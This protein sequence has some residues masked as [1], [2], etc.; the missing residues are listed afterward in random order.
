MG[1]DGWGVAGLLLVD[2]AAIA[3]D[4]NRMIALHCV[5]LCLVLTH[6]GALPYRLTGL[7]EAAGIGSACFVS[8]ATGHGFSLRVG[9]GC[10]AFFL[11]RVDSRQGVVEV[12][13]DGG[14]TLLKL[15]GPPEDP[16]R[17]PR[18]VPDSRLSAAAVWDGLTV[19]ETRLLQRVLSAPIPRPSSAVGAGRD[20]ELVTLRAIM[21]RQTDPELRERIRRELSAFGAEPAVPAE[22]LQDPQP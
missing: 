6:A 9:Q 15:D 2:G 8:D 10:G 20:A 3:V 14:T 22:P 7:M 5:T 12:E 4:G 19:E 21:R 18:T 17:T 13:F 11:R 16:T 1:S